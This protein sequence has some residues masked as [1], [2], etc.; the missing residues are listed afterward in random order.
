MWNT[1]LY[2]ERSSSY[3]L[4]L[5]YSALWIIYKFFG[6]FVNIIRIMLERICVGVILMM[7]EVV[8]FLRM[9]SFVFMGR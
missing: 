7:T 5:S 2:V 6:I 8:M 3:L 1:V 4:C 9:C